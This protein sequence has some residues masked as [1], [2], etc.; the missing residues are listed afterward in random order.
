MYNKRYDILPKREIVLKKHISNRARLY[1]Y[2]SLLLTGTSLY[3][4]DKLI[5]YEI[6]FVYICVNEYLL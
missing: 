3:M 4:V 1:I 2:C 6:R 5:E